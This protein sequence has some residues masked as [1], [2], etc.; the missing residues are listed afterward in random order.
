[1]SSIGGILSIARTAIFTSQAA[2]QV[3]S[4]NIS[5]AQTEGYSRQRALITPLDPLRMPYG[6]LGTGVTVRDIGRIREAHHDLSVRRES[7]NASGFG[8]RRDILLQAESIFGEPS[9]NGLAATLDHFWSAW[10]DLAN[11]PSNPSARALVRQRG[12]QVVDT[13]HRFDRQL[14]ELE[15]A[16]VQRMQGQVEE[17]NTILRQVAELNGRIRA[18]EAA[19]TTAGDLRDARDLAIDRAARIADVRVIPQSDGTISLALNSANLTSGI[20][21]KALSMAVQR[22]AEGRITGLSFSAGGVPID[23]IGSALQGAA[24]GLADIRVARADLDRFAA[25]LVREVNARHSATPLARNFFAE[26]ADGVSAAKLQLADS[27]RAD[28]GNVIA[29]AGGTDNSVALEIATLRELR[30]PI[31]DTLGNPLL[32]GSGNPVEHSLAGIYR[33]LVTTV[34]IRASDADRASTAAETLVRQAEMRRESVSGVSVD[35]ELIQ[36]MRHQQ[37]YA[38]ATK[39]VGVADEMLESLLSLV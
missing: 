24:D 15:A 34:A 35:E 7:A 32:D 17:L 11:S 9:E 19:G 28:S 29:G 26:P 16:T 37:A 36:L 12:M 38:A 20:E 39:L 22:T 13:V 10:S 18:A 5:N 4:H 8:V 31:T 2:I 3:A 1:M 14:D 6:S 25:H 27:I 30:I 21:A 23:P 33:D